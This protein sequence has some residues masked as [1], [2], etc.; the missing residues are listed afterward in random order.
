[1]I[2]PGFSLDALSSQNLCTLDAFVSAAHNRVAWLAI[3]LFLKWEIA[4]GEALLASLAFEASFVPEMS[5]DVGH[6][7]A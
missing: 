1:V 3:R 5:Y 6:L 7:A 4:S 2:G